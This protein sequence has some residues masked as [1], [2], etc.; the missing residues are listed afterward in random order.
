VVRGTT[1]CFQVYSYEWEFITSPVGASRKEDYRIHGEQ[2]LSSPEYKTAEQALKILHS[3]G[4]D[5]INRKTLKWTVIGV[6][7][8]A[9]IFILPRLPLFSEEA[10]FRYASNYPYPENARLL[11]RAS[12]AIFS[13]LNEIYVFSAPS[14]WIQAMLQ[15]DPWSGASW[16]WIEV[17]GDGKFGT[18][19][20]P[21]ENDTR[22]LKALLPPGRYR[23]AKTNDDFS[24]EFIIDEKTGTV[25]LCAS[26]WKTIIAINC[27]PRVTSKVRIPI[28]FF[29]WLLRWF[30]K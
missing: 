17:V 19:S 26:D 20:L 2:P 3:R 4:S 28:I 10:Y 11:F 12:E 21:N 15:K 8:T 5:K 24:R 1:C 30:V 6:L 14:D 7:V 9:F 16:E 22:A 23:Y 29:I 25:M 18:C 27:N 13:G